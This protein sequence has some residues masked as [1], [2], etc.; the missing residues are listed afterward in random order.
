ME[1]QLRA[2]KNLMEKSAKLACVEKQL[3][4]KANLEK[5]KIA[6]T[7]QVEESQP[8]CSQYSSTLVHN[9][10]AYNRTSTTESELWVTDHP[11]DE[12]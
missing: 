1:K 8:C 11:A 4:K 9:C 3:G 6:P 2:K 5:C 12:V 10:A 7:L